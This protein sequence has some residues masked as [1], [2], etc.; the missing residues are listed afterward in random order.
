MT[1]AVL[2]VLIVTSAFTLAV[3]GAVADL[4]RVRD[5]SARG[6][7]AALYLGVPALAVGQWFWQAGVSRLGAT[8]AGMYL[9]PEPLATL[10]L[11][12]PLL[13]ESL[14]PVGMLGGALVLTGVWVAERKRLSKG[15]A[16]N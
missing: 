11:A 14:G 4:S 9:Y 6:I 5:L 13:G 10:A 16:D 12:V 2:A 1:L 8:R 15:L 3:I 7:A